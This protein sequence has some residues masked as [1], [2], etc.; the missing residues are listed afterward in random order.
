MEDGEGNLV[1]TVTLTRP[2]PSN[3]RHLLAGRHRHERTDYAALGAAGLTG[4]IT[5]AAGLTTGTITVNPTAD[6]VFEANETVIVTLTGGTTNGQ[7]ITVNPQSATATGTITN[8]DAT[9]TV[10][11][12]IAPVAAT[13]VED[14]DGNLVYTVT[15]TRPRPSRRP[16]PT[17]WPAPPRAA[18]TTPPQA[19][20]ASPARSPLQRA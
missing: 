10:S 8:D 9:P 19:P 13:V 5:I 2:R 1:Y 3:D 11:V 14:G 15:L 17:R 12:S 20:R 4:S 6:N 18:P 16:S 7:P